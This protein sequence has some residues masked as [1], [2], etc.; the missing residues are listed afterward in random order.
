M[1]MKLELVALP[2]SDTEKAIKF[3][4]LVG[5]QL[6]QDHKVSDDLRFVQM[7][8]PGSACSI[9]FG[10]GIGNQ[11]K[12]GDAKGM[13][14]VVADVRKLRRE[15]V[16]RGIEVTEVDDMPWGLFAFF[17]DPDGNAWSLQ[18]LPKP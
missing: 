1:D 16:D 17:H 6:D 2:V 13:Q 15:L 18:Q 12:P 4:E 9:A 7:T 10:E 5:F 14:L 11:M 8:P 3:Y